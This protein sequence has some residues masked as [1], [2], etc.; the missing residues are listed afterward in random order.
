M[1]PQAIINPLLSHSDHLPTVP[2][3]PFFVL[4][5]AFPIRQ[6]QRSVQRT[7][8]LTTIETKSKLLD[9][10]FKA[11]SPGAETTP[12][13]GKAMVCQVLE[14]GQAAKASWRRCHLSRNLKD[15]SI[16]VCQAGGRCPN[17]RHHSEN[18]SRSYNHEPPAESQPL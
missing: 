18:C 17:Q 8:T 16:G 5:T 13:L 7:S 6:P 1:Q 3:H 12:I 4:S 14:R 15:M 2:L 9:M 10:A 11:P